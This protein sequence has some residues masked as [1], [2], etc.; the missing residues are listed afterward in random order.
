V[1][2]EVGKRMECH[3]TVHYAEMRAIGW[4]RVKLRRKLFCGGLEQGI[5]DVVMG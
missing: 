2:S 5:K 1:V 3:Y 4:I